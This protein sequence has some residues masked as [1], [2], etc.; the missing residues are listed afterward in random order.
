MKSAEYRHVN[1]F[2]YCCHLTRI[3]SIKIVFPPFINSGVVQKN[4]LRVNGSKCKM[5]ISI[6]CYLKL[7]HH[8]STKILYRYLNNR[9]DMKSPVDFLKLKMLLGSLCISWNTNFTLLFLQDL[10][11][12]VT[13]TS[14]MKYFE[15]KF[16][17]YVSNLIVNTLY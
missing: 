17:E 14:S 4:R 2:N 12:I 8:F 13:L 10:S 1:I 15:I 5:L 9:N 6:K 16:S 11:I 3:K 7:Q